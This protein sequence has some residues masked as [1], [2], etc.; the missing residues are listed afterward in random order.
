MDYAH[1]QIDHKMSYLQVGWLNV[2]DLWLVIHD[3]EGF[4]WQPRPQTYAILSQ[5][6][7][8]PIY[9]LFQTTNVPFLH[10]KGGGGCRKGTMSHFLPFFYCEASLRIVFS[11]YMS[12]FGSQIQKKLFYPGG[13]CVIDTLM[14]IKW[15][16]IST[17]DCSLCM[18]LLRWN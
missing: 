14:I 18:C 16:L 17:A 10:V 8:C 7:I 12:F 1:W 13:R 2:Q 15:C 3:S 4:Q 6:R 11:I 5:K 9:A